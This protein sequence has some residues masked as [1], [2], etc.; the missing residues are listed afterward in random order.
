MRILVPVFFHAPMG[1]LHLHVLATTRYALRAGHEITIVCKPGPFA[2]QAHA[3]GAHVIMT[4]Y[5]SD[6]VHRLFEQL[7]AEPFDLVYAHPFDSRQ[8]GLAVAEVQHIPFVLVIH[9]MYDDDL[10][11]YVD[12]TTHVIAVSQSIAEYLFKQCPGVE[13]K[14]TVLM[15]GVDSRYTPTPLPK[16]STRFRATYVSRMDA[17]MVFPLDVLLD[18]IGDERLK[19]VPIDWTFVGSGTQQ[20]KFKNRFD[21]VLKGTNQ[22]I[23]W[24]GWLESAEVAHMMRQSD[25]VVAP[26]RAVIESLALGRPTIAAGSKGY[27]GLITEDTW[28]DAEAT[29]YGGIGTQYASYHRGAL[30]DEVLKLLD[31]EFRI[32]VAVFSASLAKRYEDEA[33]QESLLMLFE[34]VV[35]DRVRPSK[36]DYAVARYEQLHLHRANDLLARQL[37]ARDEKLKQLRND[38]EE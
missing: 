22:S 11:Y 33:I 8:V 23:Y 17:D 3:L 38:M 16:P 28:E 14:T 35:K 12:Q 19:D 29:N 21:N 18:G 26:S 4:D 10:K 1:G 36:I 13:E 37:S 25:F 20:E 5:T 24:T 9:G 31:I 6:D 2:D 15:N 34:R 32:Q 7:N 27:H 30:A